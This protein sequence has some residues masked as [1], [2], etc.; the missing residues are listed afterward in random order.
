MQYITV[1]HFQHPCC[2]MTLPVLT[3]HNDLFL[4]FAP[5]DI[6]RP[7]TTPVL[8]APTPIV[9]QCRPRWYSMFHND[10]GGRVLPLPPRVLVKPSGLERTRNGTLGQRF[11]RAVD[12]RHAEIYL[13]GRQLNDDRLHLLERTGECRHVEPR[14]FTRVR[15]D[16]HNPGFR[17]NRVFDFV[18]LCRL[19]GFRIAVVDFLFFEREEL[20]DE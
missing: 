15:L 16:E 13:H 5:P 2:S 19:L 10:L 17:E 20:P 7:V 3:I 9:Q 11:E 8:F 12:G 14:N 4:P 18:E 1:A 6:F